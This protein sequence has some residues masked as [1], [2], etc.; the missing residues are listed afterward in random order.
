MSVCR[1]GL[2][3]LHAGQNVH[4]FYLPVCYLTADLTQVAPNNVPHHDGGGVDDG[5]NV[6]ENAYRK[7][8]MMR[9]SMQPCFLPELKPQFGERL[10]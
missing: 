9:S 3:V 1:N 2:Q 6:A 7:V 10:L 5:D 8:V 4:L